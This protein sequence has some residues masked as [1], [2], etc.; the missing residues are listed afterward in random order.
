MT[1][2]QQQQLSKRDELRREGRTT[3]CDF[4]ATTYFPN[5]LTRRLIHLSDKWVPVTRSTRARVAGKLIKCPHCGHEARVYHFSWCAVQ[6]SWC[7][8]MVDKY[9][10]SCEK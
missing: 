2:A 4:R 7:K 1:P 10:W 5:R 8:R 3:T 6:C 9:D